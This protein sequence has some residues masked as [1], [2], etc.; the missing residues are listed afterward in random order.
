MGRHP[1]FADVTVA[2]T[3]RANVLA[4]LT[5]NPRHAEP[6]DVPAFNLALMP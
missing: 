4:V 6:F 2:G 3:A 1:G 5:E